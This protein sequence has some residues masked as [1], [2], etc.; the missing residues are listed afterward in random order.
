M[1]NNPDRGKNE[2]SQVSHSYLKFGA[3]DEDR[4]VVTAQTG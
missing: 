4:V 1:A 2:S 3:H